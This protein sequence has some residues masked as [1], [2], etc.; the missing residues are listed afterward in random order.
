MTLQRRS[1]LAI[2]GS[3]LAA[4]AGCVMDSDG[5]GANGTAD[6]NGNDDGSA[7][8]D[9]DDNTGGT[10]AVE[11][12]WTY[13]TGG[14]V[15]TV[16]DGVIYG[17][18]GFVNGSGGVLA[19]D[20][21]TGERDWVYGETGG[22]S[23]YT[24]PVVGDHIYVGFGDDAI[25]SENGDVTAL[26][27]DGT[28]RWVTETGS[29]YEPLQLGDGSLYF[30][31]DDGRV[32]RIDAETGAVT[33]S[34]STRR[35]SDSPEA[36]TVEAVHNGVVYATTEEHVFA[37]D[38][39]DG[40]ERWLARPGERRVW[41]VETDRDTV[42]VTTAGMVAALANGELL[43]TNER[44]GGRIEAIRDGTIYAVDE[45][46]LAAV[47]ADAGELHWRV[48]TDESPTV[49]IGPDAIYLGITA[50][51]AV[52]SVGE[53]VWG[54]APDGSEIDALVPDG[55]GVCVS[56]ETG[57]YRLGPDG[58]VIAEADVTSVTGVLVGDDVYAATAE[59]IVALDL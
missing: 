38:A 6:R 48:E 46:S 13:D 9:S 55:D 4:T 15:V 16:E 41:S 43:W 56:T 57:V 44:A 37:L 3:L 49:G 10:E 26:A 33:W 21:E 34:H 39:A 22:Y 35:A 12:R 29:V 53:T 36:P 47:D 11:P 58:T 52:D 59:R 28:E 14:S 30:G 32:Y 51:R 5:N 2:G 42:Y 40:S 1:F 54:N 25:G 19:L 8:D 7:N 31:S 27:A 24:P 20:A 45:F 18:E 17:R 50:V 23:T